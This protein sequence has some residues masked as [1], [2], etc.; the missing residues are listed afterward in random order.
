[1][2]CNTNIIETRGCRVLVIDGNAVMRIVLTRMLESLGCT[3]SVAPS[4]SN[5][6]EVLESEPSDLILLDGRFADGT[7]A[8]IIR[9]VRSK[10]HSTV[11]II[12]VSSDDSVGHIREM[13]AAGADS[14]LVKPVS[15]SQIRLVVDKILLNRAEAGIA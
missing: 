14:F 3:V 8:E 10:L 11:P 1:M 2:M 15:I 12:V 5:A 13:L 6:I 7:G 4:V 9:H